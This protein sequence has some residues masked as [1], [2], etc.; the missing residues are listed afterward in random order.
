MLEALSYYYSY[1]KNRLEEL[2]TA[3]WNEDKLKTDKSWKDY[4]AKE[5]RWLWLS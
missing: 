3:L 5:G 4:M 2:V 1:S